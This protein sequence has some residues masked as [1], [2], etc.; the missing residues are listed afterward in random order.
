V[1]NSIG[2]RR[3][4]KAVGALTK[5]LGDADAGVAG[6]AAGAL[7]KIG[8]PAATDALT[9]ALAGASAT[10]KP[11]IAD[12]CLLCADRLLTQGKKKDALAICERLRGKDSPKAIRVAA[13]RMV[14]VAKG[15]AGVPLL[16][17]QLKS[18]DA[19]MSALALMLAR[20]M[21]GK[22][23]TTA[24]AAEMDKL[25]ADKQ[26]LL[27]QALADRCCP[28]AAPTVVAAAKS[29]DPKVRA[30]AIQALGKL[31]DASA[32][33]LLLEAATGADAD[34]AQ[35]AQ[36]SLST[37]RGKDVDAAIVAAMEKGDAK[38]RRVAIETL[39]LR[40]STAGTAVLVKA[41]GD[42]DESVRIAA[43]K[44]LGTTVGA[45][46]FGTLA[47]LV[48]KAPGAKETAA[49]EAAVGVACARM[50]DKDACAA[51]LLAHLPQADA[52]HKPAL[53]RALSQVGGAKAL[54][55]VRKATKDAN[56]EV[57]DE[58][59]RALCNWPNI[60]AAADMLEIAKTSSNAKHK[61]FALRGYT[62][63]IAQSELSADKKL[64][65]CKDAMALA[66]R[67]DER[68][69]VLG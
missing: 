38:V 29:S 5:L 19:A 62:R 43:I 36:T 31:G 21:P 23:V 6:A 63:L 13:T 20:Q 3:D 47:E 7:G 51:K 66:A 10:V 53:L 4:P 59:V 65:M 67:D 52:A 17:A 44:A 14:I 56:E 55:A 27:L 33:S 60:E 22:E 49:A 46:D 2:A 34:V 58:A 68:K 40:R 48:A 15:S 57:Q 1:I 61:V 35:A 16:I 37:L 26:A 12:G 32:V 39:G 69:L 30:A 42:A 54:E 45:T 25:P 64:A 11:S 50:T 18:N 8:G 41:A 24:L 28:A 9:K